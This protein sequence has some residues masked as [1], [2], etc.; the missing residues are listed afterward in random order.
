MKF[1]ILILLLFIFPIKGITSTEYYT[2]YQQLSLY[3]NIGNNYTVHNLAS[4]F[5]REN[6]KYEIKIEEKKDSALVTYY[7]YDKKS[8]AILDLYYNKKSICEQLVLTMVINGR[9]RILYDNE[10]KRIILMLLGYNSSFDFYL[11]D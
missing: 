11:K 9:Y 5:E 7:F 1:Y 3:Q 6:Y 8:L 2:F 4:W 10:A